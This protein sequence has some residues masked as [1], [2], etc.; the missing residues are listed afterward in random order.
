MYVLGINA[1]HAGPSACLIQDGVVVAAAEEERFNRVKYC[2]GF[3]T[4]AIEWCL[5]EA[6]ISAYDLAHVGISRDPSA[7]LHRKVPYTLRR[8]PSFTLIRDRLASAAR[9][10]DPKAAM[11]EALALRASDLRAEF[12][13]VKHHVAHMASERSFRSTVVWDLV[14]A[15]DQAGMS[16]VNMPQSE[17]RKEHGDRDEGSA[18]E[19]VILTL[20]LTYRRVSQRSQADSLSLGVQRERCRRYAYDRGWS[21][22]PE[23]EFA[24]PARTYLS[25]GVRDPIA[26]RGC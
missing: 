7:S 2:A 20:A 15:S 11:V 16:Q 14:L 22:A 10:R 17:A 18:P 24:R 5:A 9:V 19:D 12:H 26:S 21:V 1:Y 8:R 4:R 3:P 6:G 23:H 25:R 13:N